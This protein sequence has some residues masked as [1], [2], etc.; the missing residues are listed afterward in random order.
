MS[1]SVN[2][3]IL[4]GNLTKDPETRYTNSGKAV[5]TLFIATNERYKKDGEWHDK[6]NYHNVIAWTPLAELAAQ[7]LKKGSKVYIE[8]RV[9][10][11]SYDKDGA[12]KYVTETI[13]EE[14]VLLGEKQST[15]EPA[16]Q[17]VE[18]SDIPF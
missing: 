3:H 4:L 16:A 1:K 5:S 15:S 10:T 12:K 2:R 18:D 11:R 17:T 9:E 7:Y 6:P 13:A 8:G 14:M